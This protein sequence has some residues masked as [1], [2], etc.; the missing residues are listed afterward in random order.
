[1]DSRYNR[2]E[3]MPE[4]GPERQQ[5]LQNAR[6]VAIG[7]GG[8]KSTLL[9]SLVSAGI[10]KL[11]VIEFDR[12]ELSN[13]NRQLL[14]RTSDIGKSKA[15][16][17]QATLTDLNPDVE[18][19][20][21]NEK[22]SRS[23]IKQLCDSFDFVVEGGDSPSG[24][25]LI[26]EYCLTTKKPFVHASAQF[27]Y[28]YVFSVVPALQTACFACF[29]PNDHARK[30]HTGPVPISVLATSVAGSLGAAEV[31]KWYMGYHDSML[32]NRRLCFSS[33]LLS[34]E[35]TIES[36]PRRLDC[37]IC[38]TY[39]QPPANTESWLRSDTP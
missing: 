29:F 13:L 19:E 11:R 23:S 24:R 34:G 12:V 9:M 16:A 18:I 6:V 33:L 8:V 36:Q 7:A 28:G 1:M 10:G 32:V 27:N 37:P 35:F 14:Y 2:Q 22:V 20:T 25:N 26:N 31:L 17:C 15:L 5:D 39:Y 30:E 21:I 4:W 3:V 38:S